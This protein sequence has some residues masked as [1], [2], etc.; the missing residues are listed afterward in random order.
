M[1]VPNRE[2]VAG[3]FDGL[4]QRLPGGVNW[5]LGRGGREPYGGLAELMGRWA[6]GDGHGLPGLA[7]LEGHMAV[8]DPQHILS[9]VP[10]PERMVLPEGYTNDFDIHSNE[11][12]EIDQ[13]LKSKKKKTKKFICCVKC[14]DPLLLSSVQKSPQDKIWALRCSHMLDQKCLEVISSPQ[15]N[16]DRDNISRYPPPGL[17]VLGAEEANGGGGRGK[18]QK[19]SKGRSKKTS[20]KMVEYEWKCPDVGCGRKHISVLKEAEWKQDEVE[21]AIQVYV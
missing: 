17:D 18:R 13:D 21:G 6:G 16:G 11:T 5:D 8:G 1:D 12:I 14:G 20:L 9:E 7:G 2:M 3:I 10:M 15:A 19:T 4:M